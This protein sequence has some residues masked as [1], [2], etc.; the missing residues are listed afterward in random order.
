MKKT[1]LLL[2][3]FVLASCDLN[4]D[5]S[6]NDVLY[7]YAP[8]SAVELPDSLVLGETYVFEVTY[9]N[10]SPCHKIFGYEY[11]ADA[12]VFAIV[13][14]YRPDNALCTD[15][16]GSTEVFEWEFTVE[17]NE[18]HIFKFWQGIDANG[19]PIFLTKEVEVRET[20]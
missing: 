19:D 5:D 15:T 14:S 12:R 8:I 3:L 20:I 7:A 6:G 10:P 17:L 2:L 18:K 1:L 16:P 4:D 13:T 11:L 9:R